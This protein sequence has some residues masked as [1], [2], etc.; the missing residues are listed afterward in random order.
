MMNF[1]EYELNDIN[2]WGKPAEWKKFRYAKDEEGRYGQL[3]EDKVYGW[4]G[5][6]DLA[7]G[8]FDCFNMDTLKTKEEF[9]RHI[10]LRHKNGYI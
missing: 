9:T 7:Q 1:D 8:Y 6:Y 5:E 10:T 4:H 2:T 3:S